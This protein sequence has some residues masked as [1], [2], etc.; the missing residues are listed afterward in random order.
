MI[1]LLIRLAITFV[2]MHMSCV[3]FIFIVIFVI[4]G[5]QWI[6]WSHSFR[7]N[8]PLQSYSMVGYGV[9]KG[10]V[11]TT[12]DEMFKT[13]EKNKGGPVRY[14]VRPLSPVTSHA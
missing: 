14:Q 13:I 10:I 2:P 12:C 8:V 3:G 9:N 5:P 1:A 11:P 4:I 6:I 7:H